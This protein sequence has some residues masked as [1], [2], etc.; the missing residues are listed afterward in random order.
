MRTLPIIACIAAVSCGGT[1]KQDT[2]KEVPYDPELFELCIAVDTAARIP[3]CI[4]DK[5]VTGK[6]LWRFPMAATPE[7]E[8]MRVKRSTPGLE[9]AARHE[10]RQLIR[11]PYSYT[12]NGPDAACEP[13]L[14]EVACEAEVARYALAEIEI[15]AQEWV[16]AFRLTAEI[17]R[18][19]PS[20]Y[21]YE[22]VP[23]L[24]RRMRSHLPRG[25]AD[26][27][28]SQHGIPGPPEEIP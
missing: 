23:D 22:D 8:K 17:V 24:L 9:A 21:R 26:A 1:Q 19:G 6:T 12:C 3:S 5:D 20:H 15:D 27:C 28:L 2:A 13:L 10:A 14:Q 7:L 4:K 18:A 11:R 25:A 16:S